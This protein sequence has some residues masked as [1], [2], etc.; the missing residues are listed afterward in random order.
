MVAYL[1]HANITVPDIDA[2][3]TF[4]KILEPA[5]KVRHDET[6]EDKFRWAHI[7]TDDSYIAL[8]EPHNAPEAKDTRRLYQDIGLNHLAWVVEDLDA[9]AARLEE[10][11]FRRGIPTDPHPYRKR[12][13]YF[14]S[15][16]FEWEIL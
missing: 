14:D 3:I 5:F 1:E 10:N 7:G 11:G 8:Q 16:G 12:A 15:A 4:L 2:A 6:P 13:Y 9:V